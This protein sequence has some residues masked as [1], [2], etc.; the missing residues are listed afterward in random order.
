MIIKLSPQ[1][2]E[3]TL[4][5][6]KNGKV[7][8]INGEDFDFSPMQLGSTLPQEAI[9][10]EWFSGPV[11]VVDDQLVIT[12][13]LPLPI[14]Y[15]EAQAFPVDL[16]DVPDGPVAFPAPLSEEETLAKFPPMTV[17]ET[18]NQMLPGDAVLLMADALIAKAKQESTNE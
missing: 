5:V 7:L 13:L 12:L 2:R 17:G 8:T 3:D 6:I 10:S 16:V 1:R 4:E 18:M 15:S 9:S 11:E 14:N